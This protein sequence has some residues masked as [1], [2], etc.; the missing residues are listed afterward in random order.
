M[1]SS[2]YVENKKKDVLILK[3]GTTQGLNGTTLT[4]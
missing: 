1:G 4:A 2:V 3:E